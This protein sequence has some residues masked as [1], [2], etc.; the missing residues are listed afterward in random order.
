MRRI[1]LSILLAMAALCAFPAT[2]VY[3]VNIGPGRE[4]YELDGHSAIVIISSDSTGTSSVAVNYGVFNFNAPHFVWRFVKGE[5]DYMCRAEPLSVFLY[6][7]QN[8]GRR[9]EAAHVDMDSVQTARLLARLRHDIQP[10]FCTYRYNYV[11]DNCAT[12]PLAAIEQALGD[13]ILLAPAPAETYSSLPLTFRNIMRYNHRNYPWYQFGIDIALGSGIDHPITRRE[14]AFAPTE[15]M[16]MLPEATVGGRPLVLQ[17]TTWQEEQPDIATTG[18]TPFLLTPLFWSFVLLALAVVLAI[19]DV[20]RLRLSR[21]F[22]T[23][24]FGILTLAG[25]LLTFLIFVSVHEATSPN[26]LYVW[27]NPLCIIGAV[28]IWIMK[29]RKVV[30]CYYFINF[31]AVLALSLAWYWIPQSANVA[32][33]PL[34]AADLIRSA[35]IVYVITKRGSKR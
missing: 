22:D 23:I 16:H 4:V 3:L 20:R 5:T 17:T 34:V 27:I 21:W 18:P 35:C 26:W 19:Y 15:M 1:F 32:F 11:L 31:V 25:L 7:Y 24:F 10:Q 12:R 33:A 9:I 28:G 2:D 29:M 6:S 8:T 14:A 13:T 30:V